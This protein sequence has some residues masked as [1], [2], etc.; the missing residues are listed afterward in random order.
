ML[1]Y[2]QAMPIVEG[3]VLSR[4]TLSSLGI[5]TS[6]QGGTSN[7]SLRGRLARPHLPVGAEQGE[8]E[9]V[10]GLEAPIPNPN[11]PQVCAIFPPSDS[12]T[13]ASP[14]LSRRAAY[15]HCSSSEILLVQIQILF[16]S[17]TFSNEE[18]RTKLGKFRQ[19]L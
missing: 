3:A 9:A 13:Q 19:R 14:S 17:F 7:Q 11:G 16:E 1:A 5:R 10:L 4:D 18:S 6:R 2:F 8:A 15:C 12:P